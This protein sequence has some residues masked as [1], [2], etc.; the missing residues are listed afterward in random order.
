MNNNNGCFF[1]KC[2]EK[3]DFSL[4]NELAII[5]FDDFPVNDGHLEVIP[6]RHVQD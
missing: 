5:R 6:K 4:E 2:I 3:K 1:C